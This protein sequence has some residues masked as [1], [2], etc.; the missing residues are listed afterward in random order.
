MK[1]NTTDLD[2]LQW[3]QKLRKEYLDWHNIVDVGTVT[4]TPKVTRIPCL[5]YREMGGQVGG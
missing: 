1:Q 2:F 5:V 4:E 3:F